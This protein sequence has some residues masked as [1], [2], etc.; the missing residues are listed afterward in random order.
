MYFFDFQIF[1]RFLRFF[2]D[3]LVKFWISPLAVFLKCGEL[4]FSKA[5]DS[6]SVFRGP[7][8]LVFTYY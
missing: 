6:I 4:Y 5:P 2:L 8:L 1:F 3:F 7:S